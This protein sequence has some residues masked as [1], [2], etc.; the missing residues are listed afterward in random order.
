MADVAAQAGAELLVF[1]GQGGAVGRGGGPTSRAIMA[2]PV[3]AR[4]P[5]LKL[6]EQGE[7]II[8]RYGDPRIAARH[9]EQVI[10]ALLL[11]SL[12][13]HP[14][15][16]DQEWVEAMERMA[17]DAREAYAAL[18]KRTPALLAFF[19]QATPFPELAML[20]IASRPVVRPGRAGLK[21]VEDLRAIPWVFS[22]TQA[23]INLPGWFGLGTA[24]ELELS[25]GRNRLARLQ[26]MY[27]GWRFFASTIDNAQLSLGTADMPTARRYAALADDRTPFEA[28]EAEYQRAVAAMLR[29]SGQRELLERSPV[30]ARSIKLRNPYVDALHLAQIAL[31]RRY[32]ALSEDASEEERVL[33]LDAIHHSISGIAAGVQTTG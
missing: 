31:L 24:L 21:L 6:T 2:R 23:R 4:T 18:V 5:H 32:R 20:N 8:A 11:S 28:I 10:H 17:D 13:P 12:E 26:A 30:L 16:P 9:L 3:A 33:L 7:V 22:W 14:G 19:R 15:Q 1:H 25:R 29:V 27:Q